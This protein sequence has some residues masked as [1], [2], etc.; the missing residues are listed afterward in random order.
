[1]SIRAL[2]DAIEAFMSDG[3]PMW[4]I[5]REREANRGFSPIIPG[6]AEWLSLADW[7]K[8]SVVSINGGEVRLVAIMA[9]RPGS[10]TR[11]LA[12]LELLGLTPVVVEPTRE[13]AATLRRRGW[14]I[15]HVG[16]TFEDRETLMRPPRPI[17]E[18]V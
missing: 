16:T 1:M 9:A 18:A 14:C 5:M 8:T 3:R 11:L 6:D 12:S 13:F 4:E 15:E 2:A 10:F 7:D 17:R